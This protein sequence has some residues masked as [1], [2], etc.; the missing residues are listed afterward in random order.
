M[1]DIYIL[2]CLKGLVW[3]VVHCTE[4]YYLICYHVYE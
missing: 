3:H 4:I 2:A 1:M